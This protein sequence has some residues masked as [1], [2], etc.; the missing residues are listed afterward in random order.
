MLPPPIVWRTPQERYKN[1]PTRLFDL[2][3]NQRAFTHDKPA[4]INGLGFRGAEVET[5]KPQGRFRIAVLGDSVTFG[6]GVGDDETYPAQLARRL[7]ETTSQNIEVIN[8]GIPAYDTWQ[9]A[10]LLEEVVLSL[11]PDLVV[12]AFYENDIAVPPQAIRAVVNEE[13]E[14]PRVGLGAWLGD[15]WIFLLKKSRM[16]VLAQEAYQR[17]RAHWLPSPAAGRR[18]A[19]LHGDRHPALEEGWKEVDRSLRH[20]S[21]LLKRNGIPFSIVIFPMPEQVWNANASSSAYQGHLQEMARGIRVP[22]L[23]LLPAF[24]NAAADGQTLYIFW[25][26]HPNSEGHRIAAQATEAFITPVVAQWTG[27]HSITA[28]SRQIWM[29]APVRT[30]TEM[31]RSQ[32]EHSKLQLTSQ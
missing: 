3:P 4:R 5:P 24:R 17:V 11:G 18:K 7:H 32:R 16:L 25:D 20:M 9:H 2:R 30:K 12:L 27:K 8:A 22:T 31:L 13:G 1:H 6:N 23:D 15:Q 29:T 14:P 26:W 19:L 21:A 28:D 10:L